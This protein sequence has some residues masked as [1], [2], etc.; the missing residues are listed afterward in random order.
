M[1]LIS[2]FKWFLTVLYCSVSDDDSL[3]MDK[4]YFTE[5]RF[6]FKMF[7]LRLSTK[8]LPSSPL[9]GQMLSKILKI[10]C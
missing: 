3:F 9:K 2:H 1:L 8:F 7:Q 6:S 10:F 5:G 4:L